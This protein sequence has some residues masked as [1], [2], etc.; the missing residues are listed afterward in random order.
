MACI[1]IVAYV[2]G[3]ESSDSG[4]GTQTGTTQDDTESPSNTSDTNT[5]P[6]S[7]PDTSVS[8]TNRP[9][10]D[11]STGPECTF[12]LDPVVEDACQGDNLCILDNGLGQPGHCEGAF[13]RLYGVVLLA[14]PSS[15]A[16][17]KRRVL[18]PI[19]RCA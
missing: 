7:L 15:P 18:G 11:T 10:P 4:S 12:D 13:G 2:V 3:C 17:R 19:M 9:Q 8:D 16:R 1:V 6:Q 5:G 14:A